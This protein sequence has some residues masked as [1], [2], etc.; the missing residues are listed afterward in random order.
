MVN[1]KAILLSEAA[2]IKAKPIS[3]PYAFIKRAFDILFSVSA[4]ILLILPMVIIALI[5]KLQDGGPVLYRAKR[6]GKNGKPFFMYKFRS[7]EI[8]ADELENSLTDKQLKEYKTEYKLDDDPRLTKIGSFLRK[9]SIDEIPQFFNVLSGKMSLVGPR[10][11]VSDELANYG[12]NKDLFLSVK[13]GLTGY[14]QAYARNDVGYVNGKR[15]KMELFYVCNH[16]VWLEIKIIF[17]TVFRVF[18]GK[19]AK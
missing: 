1:E 13:P 4:I 18:T 10:P 17:A 5:I 16:S 15:Q 3:K 2:A 19:G 14:W 8:G 7:M 9:T 12:E 11:I 6:L